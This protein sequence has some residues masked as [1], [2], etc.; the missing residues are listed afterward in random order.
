M[1]HF[2][3]QSFKGNICTVKFAGAELR[4]EHVDTIECNVAWLQKHV[5]WPPW[6]MMEPQT[7]IHGSNPWINDDG[8]AAVHIGIVIVIAFSIIFQVGGCSYVARVSMF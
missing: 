1:S 7:A 2:K 8:A 5:I 6:R 3:R 4:Y